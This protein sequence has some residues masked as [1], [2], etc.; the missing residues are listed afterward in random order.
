MR[1]SPNGSTPA[2]AP[3]SRV[4]IRARTAKKRA[5]RDIQENP[6]VLFLF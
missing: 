6:Y 3:P 1:R 4:A 5:S 2:V